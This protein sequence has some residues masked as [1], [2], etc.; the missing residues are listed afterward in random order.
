[1]T[2]KI[3]N[4]KTLKKRPRGAVV[5]PSQYPAYDAENTFETKHKPGV[6]TL[7]GESLRIA[8]D[9]QVCSNCGH[10]LLTVPQIEARV[11]A[12][13]EAYQTK[14]GL[15][16]TN[17]RQHAGTHRLKSR[18]KPFPQKTPPTQHL[19]MINYQ[20]GDATRPNTPGPAIIA[21]ICN[22]IGAWG[23]GFV[24]AVS[25]RWPEPEQTYR[26]ALASH[27]E[28][29]P[30]LGDVQFIPVGNNITVANII[31]Q[32]GT[33]SP[34]NQTPLR[35]DAVQK[36]LDSIAAYAKATRASIHMP[37]IGCGLAGGHW[38]KIEPLIQQ[39]LASKGIHTT[40][41]DL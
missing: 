15:P 17:K 24:L 22:D 16:T 20:K 6:E 35:Y 30:K 10:T 33:R 37:R 9:C 4:P 11:Q 29:K 23:A 12:T 3:A 39:C 1:M 25:R 5:A 28:T 2:T 13:V 40:V 41:Y 32:H 38:D 31:G 8:Y 27:Q 34:K 18:T 14:H 36:G 19:H 21:H 26:T 7:K